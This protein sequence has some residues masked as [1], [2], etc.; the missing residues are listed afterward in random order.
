MEELNR[1]KKD[2][3]KIIQA[4]NKEL[5]QTKEEKEKVQ[6]QKEEVLSHVNDVLENELQCI[7]CSEYFIE[8]RVSSAPPPPPRSA[9]AFQAASAAGEPLRENLVQKPGAV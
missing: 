3:E 8:V 4:K 5:E 7:I 1:S 6:A 2:F 9:S